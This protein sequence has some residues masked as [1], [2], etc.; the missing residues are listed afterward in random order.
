VTDPPR[1]TVG[2]MTY[3][4]ERYLAGAFDGV[5]AQNYDDFEVVVCDNGS[6]DATL[7]IC[8]RYASKDNRFRVYRNETNL[9]YAGNVHR[10]V[11]LA[12]GEYFRLTSHDDRIAPT[13]LARCVAALEANPRAVLSYPRGT[14]IDENDIEICP[15]PGERDL[16]SPSPSRRIIDL[17]QA[18]Q[19]CNEVYGVI[20]TDVLRRTGLIGTYVSSDRRLLVELAA[21]GEFELVDEPLF[22]R[23]LHGADSFGPERSGSL[24]A[25][26]EP[27]LSTRTRPPKYSKLG[28]D[29]GHLTIDT[30]KALLGSDL[31]PATRLT[32]AAT[33]ATFFTYRRARIRVGR[34]RRQ[35]MRKR[36]DVPEPSGRQPATQ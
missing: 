11:S 16:R 34:W 17:V 12:R 10:V 25:W 14:V 28:G 20:R 2:F 32:T 5:L 13:L 9:G 24:F 23:R 35:L 27:G 30:V 3:N 21:R 7:D 1:L 15:S 33:F 4:V 19:H 36:S 26:L 8:Q 29:F 31:P 22:Y 6:T 18:W